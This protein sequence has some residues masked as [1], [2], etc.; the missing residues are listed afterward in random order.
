[1]T[2][3]LR[4]SDVAA[5]AAEADAA[6]AR[7]AERYPE[8]VAQGRLPADQAALEQRVWRAIAADWSW[9]AGQPRRAFEDAGL[10]EKRAAVADSIRRFDRQLAAAITAAPADVRRDCTEGRDLT[11]LAQLH[12][13][14]VAPI[15]AIHAQRELVTA[16]RAMYVLHHPFREFAR[17]RARA[18]AAGGP[19]QR[20]A[21]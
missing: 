15:L 7:R 6:L 16:M 4:P 3:A 18:L 9:A 12:G 1:M 20:S 19:P 17:L 13:D 8:L 10:D 11:E 14:A 21:A 5:I 2:A